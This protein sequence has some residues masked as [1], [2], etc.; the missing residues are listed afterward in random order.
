MANIALVFI[1]A[2]LMA[3]LLFVYVKNFGHMRSSFIIGL[4]AFAILFL[5]NN[6]VA[7]YVYFD[8]AKAYGASVATPLLIINVIGTLGFATLL[9]TTLR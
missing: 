7:A 4:M 8:L 5:A 1:N 3:T 6:L 2:I 9:W